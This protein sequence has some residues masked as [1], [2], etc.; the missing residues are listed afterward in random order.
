MSHP[1]S[2]EER[3][4]RAAGRLGASRFYDRGMAL[5]MNER[6]WRPLLARRVLAGVPAG[7]RVVELGAG[8][9][10]LTLMLAAL[11]TDVGIV[12]VDGDEGMLDQAR[13]KAGAERVDWQWGLA[14]ELDLPDDSADAAVVSVVL[15]HLTRATKRR[16]L[17]DLRRVLRPG[18]AVHIADFGRP[19]TPLVRA[20]FLAVQ[21]L[22]GF[23][24]TRDHAAGLLPALMQEAG[25]ADVHRYARRRTLWGTLDLL[26]GTAP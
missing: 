6:A 8:S 13:Q 3:Y 19:A 2:T 5:T 7:G 11:R 12:A 16:A 26:T 4:V 14:G 20:T 21:L 15:H 9:G 18:G 1:T 10:T 22:D 24:T 23:E 17:E 25:F